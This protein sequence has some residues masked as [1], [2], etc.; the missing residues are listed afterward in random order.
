MTNFNEDYNDLGLNTNLESYSVK[1]E[2]IRLANKKY[3]ADEMK[4]LNE[5]ILDL[6]ETIKINKELISTLMQPKS[7]NQEKQAFQHLTDENSYLKKRL[8]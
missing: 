7:E 5:R 1:Q 4:K 3:Q 2:L 6:E 8:K